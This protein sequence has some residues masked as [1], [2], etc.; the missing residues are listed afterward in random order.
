MLIGLTGGIGSGKSTIAEGLRAM[1]YAVYDSDIAAKRIITENSQVRAKIEQLF[2]K[3]VYKDGIYQTELVSAQVFANKQLLKQLN[4]IVHP[5]VILDLQQWV[6]RQNN[7]LC[8]VECAI[9]YTSGIY[10]ICDKIIT[11]TA[12]DEIRIQR[13]MIR[14]LCNIDKVLARMHAQ[15]N[16]LELGKADIVVVNDGTFTIEE[17]CKQILQQLNQLTA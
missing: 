4:T 10:S 7:T 1:G 9:L 8:F 15:R 5:A 12:P 11:V 13:T 3:N 17:L 2:G 6:N 16:E 14:D